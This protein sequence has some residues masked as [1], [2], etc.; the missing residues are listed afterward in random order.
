M[1]ERVSGYVRRAGVVIG[2]GVLVVLAWTGYR[3]WRAWSDLDR[4]AF[5]PSSARIALEDAVTDET[6]API[7]DDD[8]AEDPGPIVEGELAQEADAYARAPSRRS[9]SSEA[10]SVTSRARAA[11][12]M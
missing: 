5:D 4:V 9:S 3:L 8:I 6:Y 7:P 2:I 10:I 11:G 12:P 1:E